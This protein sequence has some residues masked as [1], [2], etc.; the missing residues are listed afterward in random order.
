MIAFRALGC[1]EMLASDFQMTTKLK[2]SE[3]RTKQPVGLWPNLSRGAA[4]TAELMCCGG[5]GGGGGTASVDTTEDREG[6][7]YYY[8]RQLQTRGIPAFPKLFHLTYYYFH[9]ITDTPTSV[10]YLIISYY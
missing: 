8:Y 9:G 3:L 6:C 2:R 4:W 1:Q 7:Y 5:G 10:Q